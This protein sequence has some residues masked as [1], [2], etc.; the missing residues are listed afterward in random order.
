MELTKLWALV[1]ILVAFVG[2]SNASLTNF[3]DCYSKCFVF[4]LIEPS[5]NLCTCTSRCLKECIF[6]SGSDNS[7]TSTAT[8][9]SNN[10]VR[11]QPDS[12]N[13]NFCKLGCAFSTCSTLSSKHQPNGGKMDD[14][15]GSCSRMCSRNYSSP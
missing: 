12:K 11:L 13:L 7:T 5:Q 6:N 3:K 2:Q 1:L 9:S 14:C 15:V 10:D 8:S 4:C